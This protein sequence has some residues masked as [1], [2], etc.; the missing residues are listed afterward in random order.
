MHMGRSMSEMCW[1]LLITYSNGW[2]D[3]LIQYQAYYNF[4]V[5]PGNTYDYDPFNASIKAL[6]YNNLYGRG[7]CVDQVKDC[8]ARGIDEICI[9]AVSPRII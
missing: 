9:A 4:T 3:P 2:F 1:P 7:N 8:N 6:L 5:S